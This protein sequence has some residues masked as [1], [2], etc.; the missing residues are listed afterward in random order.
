MQ[1]DDDSRDL[2]IHI[3]CAYIFK[4]YIYIYMHTAGTREGGYGASPA[5]YEA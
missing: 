3:Q 5:I 2:L 1:R 4:I